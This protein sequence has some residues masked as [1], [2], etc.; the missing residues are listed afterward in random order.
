MSTFFLPLL[1]S[2]RDHFLRWVRSVIAFLDCEKMYSIMFWNLGFITNFLEY[3][4]YASFIRFYKFLISL[5]QN[6]V[7]QDHNRFTVR[8]SDN[9]YIKFDQLQKLQRSL[10]KVLKP[11]V[12]QNPTLIGKIYYFIYHMYD[13]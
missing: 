3:R 11:L 6:V 7:K 10:L 9:L 8:Q 12:S 5:T 13:K 4:L 1:D 2:S